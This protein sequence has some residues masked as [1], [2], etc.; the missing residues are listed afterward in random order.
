MTQIST[1]AKT[2]GCRLEIPLFPL[3]T[4]LYPQGLLPLKIF[5]VR[6]LD[7]IKQCFKSNQPFGVVTLLDG[8]EVRQPNQEVS[9]GSYG[10]LA[11][12]I[13]FDAVSPALYLIMT[14]GEQ[15]FE[16]KERYCEKNGLWIAEVELM[17]DDDLIQ[18]PDELEITTDVLESIL[19]KITQASPNQA[20]YP[21]A[22]PWRLDDCGWV[23]NRWCELL[24]LSV[25]QKLHL[26]ALDNPRIRLDLVKDLLDEYGVLQASHSIDKPKKED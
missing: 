5:E 26:L 13:Q 22:Y 8:Q 21:I 18:V 23:A 7:M 17:I 1:N 2:S 24:P 9:F 12:V 15:R 25:E 4:T 14:Q 20:A 11:K 6:Y 16:I 3:G 10:T 19:K